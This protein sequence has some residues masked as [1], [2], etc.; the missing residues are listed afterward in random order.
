M[1]RHNPVDEFV[2]D[3]QMPD[4]DG[5]PLIR[6]IRA[7]VSLHRPEKRQGKREEKMQKPGNL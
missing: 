5:I 3:F 2:P 7:G 4:R 1:L 6:H